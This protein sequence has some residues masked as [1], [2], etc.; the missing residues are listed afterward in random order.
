[1]QGGPRRAPSA[2]FISTHHPRSWT[3]EV[4]ISPDTLEESTYESQ[5]FVDSIPVHLEHIKRD[6][7]VN[8]SRVVEV[9][10]AGRP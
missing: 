5:A 10:N 3:N 8:Y 4:S 2:L 7:K 1:M 9:E 6:R